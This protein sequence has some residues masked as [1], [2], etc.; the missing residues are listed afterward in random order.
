PKIESVPAPKG[1]VLNPMHPVPRIRN[2]RPGKRWRMPILN[3]VGDAVQP[4]A[5]GLLDQPAVKMFLG[6]GEEG[7]KLPKLPAGPAYVDAEVLEEVA[8][9]NIKGEVHRCFIIQ[10]RTESQSAS[11]KP[12][13]T[14]VRIRDGAV[15][16]QEAY[17]LGNLIAL[18]RE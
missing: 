12:A 14:Y 3:P 13:R 5:Q 16:R 9:V 8:D 7:F 6:K 4:I 15:M 1:T 11:D 18:Q 2:V 17:A 10:Y